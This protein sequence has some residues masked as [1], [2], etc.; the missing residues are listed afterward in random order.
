MPFA[1]R[2]D[3]RAALPSVHGRPRAAYAATAHVRLLA[4][5]GSHCTPLMSFW[6]WGWLCC[7]HRSQ[8]HRKAKP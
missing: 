4:A 5:T 2:C 3:L 8:R 6:Q 1:L 7:V